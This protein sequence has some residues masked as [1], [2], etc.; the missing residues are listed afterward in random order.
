MTAFLVCHTV[1]VPSYLLDTEH[2]SDQ[3]GLDGVPQSEIPCFF[4]VPYLLDGR[5]WDRGKLREMMKTRADSSGQGRVRM[6]GF[7]TRG[8]CSERTVSVI[9]LKTSSSLK[10]RV[11]TR[12]LEL[13]F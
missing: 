6:S 2:A 4:S 11:S 8:K 13:G 1:L 10:K 9:S 12:I 5:W 7:S 3:E